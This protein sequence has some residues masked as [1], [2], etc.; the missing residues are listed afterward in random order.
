MAAGSAI[1]EVH[2]QAPAPGQ[3]LGEDAA[4]QQADGRAGTGDRAEDAERLAALAGSVNVVASRRERRRGE[5]RAEQALRGTSGDEHLEGAGCTADGG[6]DGEAEQA[7]DEGPFAA[8]QVAEPAAEEQQRA[9]RQRVGGDDPL[10]RVVVK[11][12][13]CCALGSAMFTM[14]ASR[15]TISCATAMTARM[16][17]RR[18]WFGSVCEGMWEE[19][20]REV[21]AEGSIPVI[22]TQ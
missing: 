4:E 15:T 21:E 12:R 22:G 17:Q 10:A 18:A 7:A 9:E 19:G 3:D 13:S 20:E 2:V 5:Q 16:S 6:G 11:P 14:V 1:Q 8:E